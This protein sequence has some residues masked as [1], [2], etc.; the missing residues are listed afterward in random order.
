ME[1][2]QDNITV[3]SGYWRVN[4]KYG[5]HIKYDEWFKNTLRINQR[6]YFF[7]DAEDIDYIKKFRGDFET[8]FI[9]YTLDS[10]HCS[11]FFSY[12][13]GDKKWLHP[14]HVPSMEVSLIW[15][16]KI[17]LIKLAKDA[18]NNNQTDFYMYLQKSSSSG[19]PL[20]YRYY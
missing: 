19:Y 5:G 3:V 4:N 6:Y 12:P 8:N 2:N 13:P 18:D 9:P 16:E 14:T 7:C 10:F 1:S 17:H 11:K 15:H 20:K